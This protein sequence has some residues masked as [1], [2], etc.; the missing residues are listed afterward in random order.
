MMVLIEKN[1][2][3][4]GWGKAL[5]LFAGCLLFSISGRLNSGIY[6]EQHILSAVSDHYYLTYF[7]LPLVL[8]SCFSFLDDDGESVILRFKSYYAYF[9]RKWFGVGLIALLLV[10]VQS[11][12][13]F[14]SGVGLPMGNQWQLPA[15]ATEAELFSVLRQYFSTPLRAF[16]VFSLYQFCGTWG[17]FGICMW[18][19]HFGG[20]K[21][22]FRLV[23]ALYLLAAVWMKFPSIQNLPVTGF[24][25]LLILHHN[26]GAQNRLVI[27]GGTL[28]LLTLLIVLS[29]RFAWRGKRIHLQLHVRGVAAY[30]FRKLVTRRNFLILCVVVGVI[31]LYKGL[32][33]AGQE[34]GREWIYTLFSGHGT[35]YFQILPFL[36]LLITGGVPLYL[37]AVFIEHTVSGQSFFVSVRASSRKKL[38]RGVLSAGMKF[39]AVYGGLW[40]IGGLTGALFF[41]YGVDTAACKLLLYAVLMKY[42]DT[43]LQYLVMMCIYVFT[44]QITIGFLALVACNLLCVVPQH[45]AAY[46]PMGLS[47]LGRIA[48]MDPGIGISAVT[49]VVIEAFL[50]VLILSWLMIFGCKKI[51]D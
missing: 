13:I 45:W 27:T 24:N 47:S 34:S 18:I 16:T 51:F 9:L 3:L 39:L 5:A 49:A 8:L 46:L 40:F 6:Y 22:S 15:G 35:G 38:M 12:A 17:I 25:H 30:Y 2:R 31:V 11:A 20:R 36:E 41:N 48:V 37:L 4:W 21:W 10:A 14:L 29:I 33:C 32:G 19:G 44:K 43:V 50:V 26:L 7:M 42:L 28:L 1:I 23:I